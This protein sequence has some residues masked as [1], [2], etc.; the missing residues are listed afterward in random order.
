MFRNQDELNAR[1]FFDPVEAELERVIG[2]G[3]VGGPIVKN[4]LFYFAFV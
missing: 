1:N 2:G 4:K 3:T